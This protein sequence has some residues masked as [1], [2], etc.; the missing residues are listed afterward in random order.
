M[1]YPTLWYGSDSLEARALGGLKPATAYRIRLRFRHNGS[2]YYSSD[3]VFTTQPRSN[4][5]SATPELTAFPN[6]TSGYLHVVAPSSRANARIEVFSLHGHRVREA[7]G[8]G[9]DLSTLPSGIYLLR[10]SEGEQVYR[11]RIMK[12]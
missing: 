12:L 9:L 5:P 6:P 8:S 2:Y 10:V 3:T 11:R 4:T 7:T 1:A